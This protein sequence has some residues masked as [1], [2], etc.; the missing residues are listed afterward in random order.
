MNRASFS[1]MYIDARPPTLQIRRTLESLFKRVT[2]VGTLQELSARLS[3]LPPT[4]WPVLFVSELSLPDGSSLDW[5]RNQPSLPGTWVM[6]SREFDEQ[7]V[8]D[9]LRAGVRDL[10]RKGQWGSL[11]SAKLQAYAQETAPSLRGIASSDLTLQKEITLDPYMRTV[12]CRKGI[13]V[14]L[15]PME[16]KIL[17]SI[18]QAFPRGLDRHRLFRM[19]W[20]ERKVVPKALDVHIFNLRRKLEHFGYQVRSTPHG[21]FRLTQNQAAMPPAESGKETTHEYADPA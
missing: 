12:T 17:A 4:E 14:Q 15:T 11:E 7:T 2:C 13:T 18:H 19:L 3:D 1:V 16:F 8:R 9:C 10:F 21:E 5:I 20:G 6:T